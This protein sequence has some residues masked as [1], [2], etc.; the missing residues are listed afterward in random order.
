MC[1]STLAAETLAATAGLDLQSGL[2]FRLKEL[3]IHPES[4]LIT[5]CRSLHDHV[6]SMTSKSAEILLPDVHE[7]REAAMPWRSWAEDHDQQCVELWWCPTD[8]QL[9]DNLTKLAT[10]ST[11]QFMESIR[12]N[13]FSLG[14]TYV[15]PRP[16]QRSL[17]SLATL[18]V[19]HFFAW[20]TAEQNPEA[21]I[22]TGDEWDLPAWTPPEWI[23]ALTGS[24]NP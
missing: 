13:S 2:V 5:D 22:A 14:E 7:L 3:D 21:A 4:V 20:L 23:G 6:Y 1:H 17:K 8:R 12:T 19:D 15:R 24:L 11:L 16:S 18:R 10:P 9:A